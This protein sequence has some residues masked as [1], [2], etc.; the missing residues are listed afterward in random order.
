MTKYNLTE[1]QKKLLRSLV[2]STRAKK[3]NQPILLTYTTNGYRIHV[4][5]QAP[6]EM[7]G[8]G[9]LDALCEAD[10]ISCTPVGKKKS[11]HYTIKQAGFDAVDNDFQESNDLKNTGV[12]IGNVDSGIRGSIIAGRDVLVSLPG[13]EPF[14]PQNSDRLENTKDIQRAS[15][16]IAYDEL[17]ITQYLHRYALKVGL[18]L[19][20]PPAQEKFRLSLFWPLEVRITLLQG[21]HEG[22]EQNIEGSVFK[23]LWLTS[24]EEI[25]PGQSVPMVGSSSSAQLEYEFDNGIYYALIDYPKDLSYRLYFRDYPLVEGRV[26]FKDLNVF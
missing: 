11:R 12:R 20:Q 26:S 24:N 3:L 22:Q 10:L 18:T 19:N 17:K 8:T 25:F 2:G 14:V 1:D 7:L 6:I 16:E 21:F 23:E 5:D 15:V 4:R 13:S 9:D